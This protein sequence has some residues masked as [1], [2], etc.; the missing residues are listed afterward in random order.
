M[1]VLEDGHIKLLSG[2]LMVVLYHKRFWRYGRSKLTFNFLKMINN[3]LKL[4]EVRSKR[5]WKTAL[6][7]VHG[8][9]YRNFRLFQ[10]L[11]GV[12]ISWCCH[13]LFFQFLMRFASTFSV[14]PEI[15]NETV[16]I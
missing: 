6:W 5:E 7:K 4:F 9:F 2:P 8:H 12:A 3:G 10:T 1:N 16:D 14:A 15:L 11:M 13:A